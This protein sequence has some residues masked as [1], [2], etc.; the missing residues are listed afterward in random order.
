VILKA[1]FA[2]PLDDREMETFYALAGDRAPPE[3]QVKELWVIAGRRAGK[4]SIASVIAAHIAAFF[5][6]ADRL[7]PGE[8][9]LVLNLAT[10]C[11]QAKIWLNY[12]RLQLRRAGEAQ[13]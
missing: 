3:R 2:I 13:E 6:H 12:V 11:D 10:D 1:A 5:G 4:D 8:R 7:R 9:A